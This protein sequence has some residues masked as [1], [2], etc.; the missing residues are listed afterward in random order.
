M[1]TVVL[2]DAA[3]RRRALTDL[4]STMLVEAGAGSGKTSL[5]AGRVIAM[6]A[7]GVHPKNIAAV[8]FTEKAASELLGRIMRMME[9]LEHGRVPR[10]LREAFPAEGPSADQKPIWRRLAPA[11]TKSRARRSMA[12]ASG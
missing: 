7:S 10:D 2:S 3:I 12:S 4:S 11:S 5:M 1:T 6:M 9:E 8:S